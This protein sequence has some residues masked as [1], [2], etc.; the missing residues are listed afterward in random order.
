MPIDIGEISVY[1]CWY[2]LSVFC[3]GKGLTVIPFN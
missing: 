3:S 2:V 1:N